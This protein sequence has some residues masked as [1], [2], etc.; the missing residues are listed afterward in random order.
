MENSD[1]IDRVEKLSNNYTK[2][3]NR[4]I[5]KRYKYLNWGNNG[6]GD[7]WCKKIFNYSV[8]YA[9][10]TFKTYSE[11]ID[12]N[13]D[14]LNNQLKIINTDNK[15]KGIIGIFV[16]SKKNND[17]KNNRPIKKEILEKIKN[18]KCIVC[19]STT[20]LVCDHK[21]DLYNDIRVLN[22][23]T[24]LLE[25]FQCLCNHCNLLKRQNCKDEIKN[26][27]LYSAKNLPI[28]NIYNFNFP[29]EF[30]NFDLNNINCKKE[31]FWYDPIEFNKKIMKYMLYTIPIVNE[32]KKIHPTK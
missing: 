25:D 23:K 27:K 10:L 20:E 11:N 7:R 13:L 5:L 24:Q 8:I 19:G 14:L 21:N 2:I 3:I 26:Q 22:I 32:I 6:V 1:I 16:H 12:E 18:N 31:S 17:N 28:Y 29:W 15:K 30:Y 4:N 9:N